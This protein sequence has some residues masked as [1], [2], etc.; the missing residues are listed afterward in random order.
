MQY[1][2]KDFN[3]NEKIDTVENIEDNIFFYGGGNADISFT[4]NDQNLG[5]GS[6][7]ITPEEDFSAWVE[8]YGADGGTFGTD[9]KENIGGIGGYIKALVK[10]KKD[11][12]YTMVVGQGGGLNNINTHGGGGKGHM[13]GGSG[14]G[15]SGLF[16]DTNYFGKEMWDSNSIPVTKEKALLIAGG[17]GGKGGTNNKTQSMGGNGGG[18][19]GT[20]GYNSESTLQERDE[21]DT[22]IGKD[23]IKTGNNGG[24]GGGWLG[25]LVNTDS[26]VINTGGSGGSGYIVNSGEYASEVITGITKYGIT[27]RQDINR[28]I[29][30]PSK[31]SIVSGV[32]GRLDNNIYKN[33]YAPQNGKVI[34]TLSEDTFDTNYYPSKITPLDT[35]DT[36]NL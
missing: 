16:I 27:V 34:I 21:E 8:L 1:K 26:S 2:I 9:D 23:G 35:Y 20:G 3:E 11:I 22:V 24:G 13:L 4:T 33:I 6:F 19:M 30:D 10:F 28:N 31:F 17:G 5:Y 36:I 15:L 32:R 18:W 25:G 29:L 7:V 12:N 14:G